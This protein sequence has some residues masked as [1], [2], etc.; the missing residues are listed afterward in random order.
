ME[1]TL[2]VIDDDSTLRTALGGFFKDK[3]YTILEAENGKDGLELLKTHKPSAVLLD[4][5]MPEMDGV[6]VIKEASKVAPEM[7]G[8]ITLMTNSSSMKY[9]S[10]AIDLGVLRYV[11]K[12]DMSLDHIYKIVEGNLGK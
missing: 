9:L 10:D 12:S 8:R 3:G 2:L 6:A 7:L 11:L 4:I 5:M 1:K